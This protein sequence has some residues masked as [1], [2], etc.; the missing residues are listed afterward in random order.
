MELLSQGADFTALD[1]HGN[2][3]LHLAALNEQKSVIEVLLRCGADPSLP[4][5]AGTLAIEMARSAVVGE[6]FLRDRNN[7]FSPIVTA[8]N[9]FRE[10]LENNKLPQ[11]TD[12]DSNKISLPDVVNLNDELDRAASTPSKS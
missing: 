8:K 3:C 7:I 2:S 1:C 10:L 6:L 12:N 11:L 9:L 4:N 5:N